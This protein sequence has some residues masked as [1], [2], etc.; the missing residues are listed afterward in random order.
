MALW[1]AGTTHQ[2][3]HPNNHTTTTHKLVPPPHPH[4]LRQNR[5]SLAASIM[6]ATNYSFRHSLWQSLVTIKRPDVPLWVVLRNTAA[7]VLPLIAGM[8][9]DHPQA[10]LAVAAGALDTMFSDQPGPYRQRLQ[11]LLL[12][13][14]A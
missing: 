2:S 6:S 12:A 7:V 14:L 10:G 3:H 4:P 8:L 13:S 5:R 11:Q 9:L 1:L